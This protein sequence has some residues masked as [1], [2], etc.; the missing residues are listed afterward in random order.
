MKT[1]VIIIGGSYAGI[2]AALQLARA[3]RSITVIDA[4]QRRNR[5]ASHS[6]GFLGRDGHAPS[7][8]AEEA[9]QQLLAYSTVRWIEGEATQAAAQGQ[10]FDVQVNGQTETATRL[11]L[12]SG[13]V[14]ELPHIE[15]LRER[16]GRSVFHCPYCHGYELDQGAI[17]VLAN[18]EMAMHQAQLLP[19]W[20]PVTLLLNG[21]FT[22]DATQQAL[23]AR[24]HVKV[25]HAR[26]QRLEGHASVVLAD[27]RTLHFNGLFTVPTTR[28]AS[29]LPHQLGCALEQG[30]VG[31]YLKVNEM[32]E[33]SVRGVFA[34]GD[35]ARG[36]GNVAMAVG[37]GAM[38]GASVHR[39]LVFDH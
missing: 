24:R 13:V 3:R 2:S 33:T 28:M 23:L 12:A 21:S 10:G 39:S 20:G 5:F 9:R 27:G 7:A 8:I 25:E 37:D 29:E 14:D 18:N 22:P 16:W 1:D 15:G 6:H 17:G 30:P 31:S 35:T 38:T 32:K 36:F 11:V 19:E 4:G 34:C 26:V